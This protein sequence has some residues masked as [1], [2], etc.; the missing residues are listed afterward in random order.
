MKEYLGLLFVM[1]LLGITTLLAI[2]YFYLIFA[3]AFLVH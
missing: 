2:P 3:R 1:L